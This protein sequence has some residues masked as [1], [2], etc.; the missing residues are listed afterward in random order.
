MMKKNDLLIDIVP[1]RDYS[2]T[3]YKTS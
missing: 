2:K 3:T 1:R